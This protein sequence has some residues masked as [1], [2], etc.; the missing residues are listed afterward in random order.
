MPPGGSSGGRRWGGFSQGVDRTSVVVGGG[1]ERGG[2]AEAA[3]MVG[4]VGRRFHQGAEG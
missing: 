4:G 3:P 1:G 2:V